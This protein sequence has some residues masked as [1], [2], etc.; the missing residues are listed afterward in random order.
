MCAT[1]MI[2]QGHYFTLCS[3]SDSNRQC[4]LECCRMSEVHRN[5]GSC[6]W[7][8]SRDEYPHAA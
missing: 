8:G 2:D 1:E 6:K 3:Q 4:D 5:K 7:A